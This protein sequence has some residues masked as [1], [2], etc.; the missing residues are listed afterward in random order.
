MLAI[1]GRG[2]QDA[3][4]NA[5]KFCAFTILTKEK[6]LYSK[7]IYFNEDM[8]IC[9]H[10]EDLLDYNLYGFYYTN[11]YLVHYLLLKI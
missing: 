7:G 9:N 1:L 11:S 2:H 8:H 5:G 6:L 3:A 10:M 4:Y